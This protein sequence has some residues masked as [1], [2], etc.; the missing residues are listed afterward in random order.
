MSACR[1]LSQGQ[2]GGGRCRADWGPESLLQ[3][4]SA[5]LLEALGPCFASKEHDGQRASLFT[6]QPGGGG[7]EAACLRSERL[8]RTIQTRRWG[9]RGRHCRTEGLGR[10]AA[11]PSLR[12]ELGVG[13]LISELPAPWILKGRSFA[14][15]AALNLFVL[16]PVPA[17]P[18]GSRRGDPLGCGLSLSLACTGC[19]G[20]PEP[21]GGG[22]GV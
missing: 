7:S 20:Q 3:T 22:G 15:G 16:P 5:L 10:T 17:T 6:C 18:P 1:V 12:P 8:F 4:L 9:R 14:P 11:A 13:H 19:G 21:E 2:A